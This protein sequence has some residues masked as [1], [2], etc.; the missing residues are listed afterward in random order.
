[1]L[2]EE[3]IVRMK[4]L[5]DLGDTPRTAASF[6][7]AISCLFGEYQEQGINAA[8]AKELWRGREDKEDKQYKVACSSAKQGRNKRYQQKNQG[9]AKI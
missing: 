5:E 4:L 7:T 8:V 1:M 2:R 3:I 6:C 9:S